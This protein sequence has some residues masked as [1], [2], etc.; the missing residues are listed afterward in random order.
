M[1]PAE[2]ENTLAPFTFAGDPFRARVHLQDTVHGCYAVATD[3]H[4][5][6]V[7]KLADAEAASFRAAGA[8]DGMPCPWTR[9]LGDEKPAG[10]W[11]PQ[12][13]EPWWH[14][15]AAWSGTA[16]LTAGP[17]AAGVTYRAGVP[18]RTGKRGK[19]LALPVEIVPPGTRVAGWTVD[20][21]KAGVAI[22]LDVD[23]LVRVGD[24]LDRRLANVDAA[25]EL[26]PVWFRSEAA[27]IR[28]CR[29]VA[30][31]MPLRL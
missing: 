25:G 12:A 10:T 6:A 30:L 18:A 1:T 8:V 14:L 4:T 24:F 5:M 17:D 20:R 13:S 31:V 16:T 19:V 15:P 26:Y 23:Y 29:R 22:R 11:D 7:I 27:P 28:E 3:G 9:F 21:R 2:I